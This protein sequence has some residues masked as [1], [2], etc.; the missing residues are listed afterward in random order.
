MPEPT[1][2]DITPNRLSRLRRQ[3]APV[4]SG[5]LAHVRRNK[6]RS[7]LQA[8]AALLVLLIFG[9]VWSWL[10]QTVDPNKQ[11]KVTIEL[12]LETLD[13]RRFTEARLMAEKLRY[14]PDLTPTEL[15]GPLFV[16]G[17]AAAYEAEESWEQ[18]PRTY[19]LL[20]AGYLEEAHDRGFPEGRSAEGKFLLPGVAVLLGLA[21][22]GARFGDAARE[23][24]ER[25][26]RRGGG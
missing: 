3:L 4:A 18:D 7:A 11:P 2:H 19:Q 9:S 20:A 1:D 12:A 23:G 8:T 15:G 22:Q 17:A 26:D 25:Q 13:Q 14:S 16:L 21:G 24:Q 6:L 10:D 5:A